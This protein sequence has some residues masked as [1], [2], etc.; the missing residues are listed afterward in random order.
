MNKKEP[1]AGFPQAATGGD[2]T[3]DMER[4]ALFMA[5]SNAAT[6][7][8]QKKRVREDVKNAYMV[9]NQYF[10]QAYEKALLAGLGLDFTKFMPPRR[11][12]ALSSDEE[13][14]Y[15]PH[16]DLGSGVALPS[17]DPPDRARACIV[18]KRTR[19]RW[20]EVPL[21]LV[22]GKI[23]RPAL[24]TARDKGPVG[25]PAL[26]WLYWQIGL[27]G[28]P[29]PDIFHQDWNGVRSACMSAGVWKPVL[30]RV[31]VLNLGHGPWQGHAFHGKMTAIQDWRTEGSV[32]DPLF[33]HLFDRLC[34]EE[35]S[36]PHDFG[37]LRHSEQM[38]NELWKARCLVKL[39]PKIRVGRWYS[40][41][42]AIAEE[43]PED[44]QVAL[45]LDAHW[46]S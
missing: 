8:A 1:S 37:S 31:L 43:P 22:S 35:R 24:H 33:V 41:F 12:R 36:K 21:Q 45:L 27:R 2:E 5:E 9:P 16:K 18:N 38:W 7:I 11:P 44:N 10:M 3:D 6:K 15:V 23:A 14:Y 46:D 28:L 17:T 30:E 19:E 20:V 13:R 4:L 26:L 25:W 39:G 32:K 34:L 40:I 42:N 29:T